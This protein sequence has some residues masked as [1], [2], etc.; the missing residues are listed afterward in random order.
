[1]P[2]IRAAAL[3][4]KEIRDT[5]LSGYRQIGMA[6]SIPAVIS[7]HVQDGSPT[8]EPHLAIVPL[9]FVGYEYADGHV[10]GFALIP[11][12][13]SGLL[14]NGDFLRAMRCIAPFDSEEE[15]RT[16]QWNKPKEMLRLRRFGLKLSPTLD[17]DKRS[18]DS[19]AYTKG[20]STFSTVTPVVLDRHLKERGRRGRRRSLL[21]LSPP[22]S[23]SDSR[24]LKPW[25]RISTL[26]S[27]ARRRHNLLAM[28]RNGCVGG[29]LSR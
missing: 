14:E 10:L 24:N 26:P 28:R 13:N 7:G 29:F 1:M 11:P 16:L 27:K 17:P 4:A 12:R 19:N 25:S 9:A 2:D 5:L 15:R 20:S 18:L 23:T 21:R 3:L 22:A 6:D 8:R